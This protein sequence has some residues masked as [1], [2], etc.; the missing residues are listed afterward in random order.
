MDKK[1]PTMNKQST[2]L[3]ASALIGLL[4]SI[5]S[6]ILIRNLNIQIALWMPFLVFIP[7]CVGGIFI[8]RFIG[9]KIPALYQFGKFGETGGLNVLID[10]GV[11]NLLILISGVSTGIFFITF[12]AISFLV[13]TTNSYIWNKFWVFVKKE[14]EGETKEVSSFFLV[15]LIG[16]GINVTIA[17][18]IFFIG[19]KNIDTKILANIAAAF[20]ALTAMMWNFLGYKFVVF[21]K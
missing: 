4:A 21:K 8:V 3:K 6:L 16:L 20:G 1:Q 2:D 13:A 18:L 19:P 17:S 10:F 12:K 14:K 11:L 5:F 9:E 15:T 7:L